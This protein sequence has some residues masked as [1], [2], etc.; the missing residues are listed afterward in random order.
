MQLC[1]HYLNRKNVSLKKRKQLQNRRK[2]AKLCWYHCTKHEHYHSKYD[3]SIII[4]KSREE[5]IFLK[6]SKDHCLCN[7]F[8]CGRND[9]CSKRY[10]SKSEHEE[11]FNQNK[12]YIREY[13]NEFVIKKKIEKKSDLHIIENTKEVC[14]ICFVS[15]NNLKYI[16]CIRKGIQNINYGKYDRCCKDKAIC[17]TC[18][19]RCQDNCPFC[20]NHKLYPIYN[21]FKK[22]KEPFAIRMK[23]LKA[24]RL[25]KERAEKRR[26]REERRATQLHERITYSYFW[27]QIFL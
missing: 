19:I 18:L 24:K 2:S 8:A 20:K 17:L 22:K 14:S 11:E 4:P 9:N 25:K 5:S 7:N 6:K 10:H 21:K 15:S 26:L 27:E 1:D 12:K 23:I 13:N 16:N 3:D